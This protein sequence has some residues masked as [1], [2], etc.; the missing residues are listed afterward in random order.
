MPKFQGVVPPV[1]T[2]LNEDFSVDYASYARLLEH[3]IAGGCHGLF[4]LGSTS[5]VAVH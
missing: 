1:V 3:L 5:E 4:V 2:P